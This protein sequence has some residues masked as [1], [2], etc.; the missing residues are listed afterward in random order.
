M[1]FKTRTRKDIEL[2]TTI[3]SNITT[4]LIKQH[5][6]IVQLEQDI[7]CVQDDVD[8]TQFDCE[9]LWSIVHATQNDLDKVSKK[10]SKAKK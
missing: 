8:M 3:L 10:I 4:L 5:E 7:K 6:R 9:R 1:K 2:A